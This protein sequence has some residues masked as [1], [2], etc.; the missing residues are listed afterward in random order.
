MPLLTAAPPSA[1]ASCMTGAFPPATVTG[2]VVSTSIVPDSGVFVL[3]QADDGSARTVR[4]SGRNPNNTFVDGSENT[5]EDAWNGDLPRVGGQY[6]IAGAE[7]EGA[8]GPLDVN[9]CAEVASVKELS[10]TP[11]SEAA[12]TE[13]LVGSDAGT[14]SG[15]A[16]VAVLV[17]ATLG[18]GVLVL[19]LRRRSPTRSA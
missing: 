9:N 10:P 19:I 15:G 11:A 3:V 8:D 16:T 2:V 12:T 5:V 13:P 14:A 6:A 7:F 18:G 1:S 4:F 17:G